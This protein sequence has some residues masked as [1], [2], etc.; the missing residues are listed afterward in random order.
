MWEI[1]LPLN[2]ERAIVS[3]MLE[4]HVTPLKTN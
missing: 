4:Q 2:E 1:E 3:E